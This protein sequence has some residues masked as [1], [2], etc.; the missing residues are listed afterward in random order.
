VTGATVK[1]VQ[2]QGLE[3]PF[4]ESFERVGDSRVE[5]AIS[6]RGRLNGLAFELGGAGPETV[7]R[8]YVE[9]GTSGYPGVETK[10]VEV[11]LRLADAID[12]R[13]VHEL[14]V[15]DPKNEQTGRDAISLQVFD[16]ADSLD[17]VFEYVDLGERA[18]GD[19]YYLRVTQI[20]GEQAWSSP[21]WVGGEVPSVLTEDRNGNGG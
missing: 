1:Q 11:D 13:V 16:P 15:T 20:D 10:E 19:Y 9:P 12:G 5:F 8:V 2:A 17:Q 6:T 21:W 3:N 4:Y 14:S 18:E 7:I